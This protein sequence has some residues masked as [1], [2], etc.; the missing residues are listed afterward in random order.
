VVLTLVTTWRILR[1][2]AAIV[3]E[4]NS[5]S[6]QTLSASGQVASSS[7]LLSGG[8]SEQASHAERA[9][10]S[11]QEISGVTEKNAEHAE[12][13]EKIAH[14]ART[15]TEQGSAAMTQMVRTIGAMKEA[16]DKTAKIVKTIDEIAFQT[17][18]LALNAAVEAARAGDAGRG[19]AVVAEEVRNLANRSAVAAKDTSQLIE[20]AVVRANEGVTVSGEVSK[21]LTEILEK[22]DQVN[23][24]VKEVAVASR[25]QT[26]DIQQTAGSIT[27][28]ERIIQDNAA[29]AEETAASS[30]ELSAQAQTLAANVQHLHTLVMGTRAA[31]N[32]NAVTSQ[33]A[34][35]RPLY[36]GSASVPGNRHSPQRMLKDK[37]A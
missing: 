30:E 2:T 12:W 10:T 33:A 5:A 34:P 3:K 21:L 1:D 15:T 6:Q 20:D 24:L 8:A 19:F 16:S 27:E 26:R 17:N 11:L 4:L 37:T 25:Q 13:A 18:L 7:Q 35:I 23:G 36:S 31:G 32:G 22:V 29:T 9:A 14:E 28:M